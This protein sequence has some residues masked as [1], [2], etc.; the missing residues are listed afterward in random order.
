ML[1]SSTEGSGWVGVSS[2]ERGLSESKGITS[3]VLGTASQNTSIYQH[4]G[5]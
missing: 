2:K 1:G 5:R 4:G 3:A